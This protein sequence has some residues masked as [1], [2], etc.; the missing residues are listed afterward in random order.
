MSTTASASDRPGT[1][2]VRRPT[3][4][5][6]VPVYDVERWLPQCLQSLADQTLDDLE[7]IVVNDGSPDGSQAIIDDFVE[8]HPV[9]FT[10]Y[11]KP[12]GGLADAR[13]FGLERARGDYVG[14]VDSDD[15][16]HP[17]M[18][19]A[20]HAAATE[21]DADVVVSPPTY[22]YERG[23]RP[24]R[25]ARTDVFGRAV[26]DAPAIL[27]VSRSWA[28]NKLYRR[29]LWTSHGFRFP[30]GQWFE[31][32][33]VV[34]NVL[35]AANRVAAVD[36]PYYHYRRRRTGA[37]STTYDPRMLDVLASCRSMVDY[38]RSHPRWPELQAEVASVCTKH[39]YARVEML[40]DCPAGPLTRAFVRRAF[41]FLD[42]QLPAWRG[43]AYLRRK[44]S[45]ARR[46]LVTRRLA[47][48]GYL[49]LPLGL[50]QWLRRLGRRARG[51]AGVPSRGG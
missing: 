10:A 39:V 25:L 14:F 13:N 9:R 24:R 29:A 19:R 1:A 45:G 7:V 47:L 16:V 18:F 15:F 41:E 32:S 40:F 23:E 31:D 4:S 49:S 12:N 42:A 27:D 43:S 3:V 38:F 51:Q 2:G 48:Q 36:A 11:V 6:V 28:W 21:Q 26:A 33:A 20:L 8:R 46:A 34:Y 5:V 22:V 17:D 50:R 37:I 44:Y 30:P 35:L